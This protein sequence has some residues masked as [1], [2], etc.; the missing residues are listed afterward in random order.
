MELARGGELFDRL[1]TEG[2]VL[3]ADEVRSLLRETAGAVAYMHDRGIVH[4][5]IKPENVLLTIP[6]AAASTSATGIAA[7]TASLAARASDESVGA[8]SSSSSS[9]KGAAN[10]FGQAGVQQG[11]GKLELER[12]QTG[13]GSGLGK[14]LLA[15]F[16][17]SFRL[18]EGSA[19]GGKLVKE[20]TVAYSAPEVVENSPDVDHKADV[21]SLGVIAYVMVRGGRR[22][23]ARAG[24]GA[25]LC[26]GGGSVSD[27][28]RRR[29][30][31]GVVVFI[32]SQSLAVYCVSS[33]FRASDS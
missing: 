9:S 19:D 16:G 22:R 14:V 23:E 21:W 4:G 18:R 26:V 24:A 20:Y 31:V 6:A 2:V 5:D 10:R 32:V 15:D 3:P 27:T 17:S 7:T 25:M 33:R 29:V 1:T 30:V 12:E 8:G 13:A 11:L 28:F